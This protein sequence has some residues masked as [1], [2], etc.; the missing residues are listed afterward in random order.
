M[1]SVANAIITRLSKLSLLLP[2]LGRTIVLTTHFMDEADI[3][4]D[5]I[6]IMAEGNLR[7]CGSSTFLKNEYGIGYSL[8]VVTHDGQTA[9]GAKDIVKSIVASHVSL[10]EPA[11]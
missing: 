3:L 5:R 10:P 9:V 7:C 8:T 1:V 2:L 4:G 11:K 6:A